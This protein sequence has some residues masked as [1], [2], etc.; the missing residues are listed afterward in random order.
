MATDSGQDQRRELRNESAV[1]VAGLLKDQTGAT[2]SY[3]I[4][5]D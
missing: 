5:L 2:R 1:N 4:R 3:R